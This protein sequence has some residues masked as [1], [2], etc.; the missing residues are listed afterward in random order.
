MFELPLRSPLAHLVPS[1]FTAQPPLSSSSNPWI[2]NGSPS[3]GG[4]CADRRKLV[5]RGRVENP[6][7]KARR[8]R[9]KQGKRWVGGLKT[10]E[11]ESQRVRGSGAK[12]TLIPARV[13]ARGP[14]FA[15]LS[16]AASRFRAGPFASYFDSCSTTSIPT[17]PSSPT[18]SSQNTT[19]SVSLPLSPPALAPLQLFR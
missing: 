9:M 1:R 4:C 6:N 11:C 2:Q 7:F 13:G 15:D 10:G 19:P 16:P 12:P 17:L 3:G 5:G 14:R 18:N 8:A